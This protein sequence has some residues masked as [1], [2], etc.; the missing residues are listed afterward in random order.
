MTMQKVAQT[1]LDRYGFFVVNAPREHKVGEVIDCNLKPG[2]TEG[3]IPQSE[4]LS[5]K[6]VLVAVATADDL[7]KQYALIGLA[8]EINEGFKYRAVAE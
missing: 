7:A 4:R 5:V 3:V 1:M 6:C 2:F 8:P